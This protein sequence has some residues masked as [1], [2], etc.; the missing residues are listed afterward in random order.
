MLK[1]IKY[2]SLNL[3]IVETQLYLISDEKFAG[4]EFINQLMLVTLKLSSKL[5]RL[6]DP[7]LVL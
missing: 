4:L 7:S 6:L 3:K 2:S 1:M 5:V